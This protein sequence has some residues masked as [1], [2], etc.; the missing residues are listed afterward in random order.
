MPPLLCPAV[1]SHSPLTPFATNSSLANLLLTKL[2]K[3][4]NFYVVFSLSEDMMEAETVAVEQS[5]APCLCGNKDSVE[6]LRSG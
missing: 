1:S 6:A 2:L 3:R 5:C 4:S